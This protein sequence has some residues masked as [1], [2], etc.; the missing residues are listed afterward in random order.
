MGGPEPPG[1]GTWDVRDVVHLPGG[2]VWDL[3]GNVGEWA[4]DT[5]QLQFEPCWSSGGVLHD[6]ACTTTSP[7]L[8]PA[9]ASRG[10]SW[11]QGSDTLETAY[12]LSEDGAGLE[13]GVRCAHADP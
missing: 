3:A 13:I 8:G 6:P 12:R 1:T 9:N 7:S 5:Y 4:L 2:D 11:D 10:S